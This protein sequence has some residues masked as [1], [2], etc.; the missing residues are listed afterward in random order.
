M[1]HIDKKQWLSLLE[2]YQ[3]DGLAIA[4]AVIDHDLVEEGRQHIDWLMKRYPDLRPEQLHHN[5]MAKD[6]FWV[7]LISD[8]RLL[9]VVEA[10]IGPNI[11]L[12]ASHY[13][14]KPPYTGEA[15]LWHQDGAFWPLQPMEVIT[16]WLS[17]DRVTPENG[18]MRVI[19]GTQH[20]DLQKIFPRMDVKN[21][22]NASIDEGL[23]DESRA[24][25]VILEPGDLSI[26]HPNVIHG[27]NPNTSPNWRRGLTI[28]YIP[29]TTKIIT[30]NDQVW[31]SAFLLRGEAV[32]GVNQYQPLPAYLPG[33]SMPFRGCENWR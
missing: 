24:V 2:P 31:P 12:F 8:E 13:I 21:V 22:L 1:E 27:S 30:E 15:V 33:E 17:L 9:D 19:P 23:V 5:L 26:H 29:A 18:C 28:R 25:D 10:F 32:P 16:I 4:R 11:A 14:A 3:R 7:R 20:L 6:A